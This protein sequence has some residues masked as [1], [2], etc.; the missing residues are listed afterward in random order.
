MTG[1]LSFI[2]LTSINQIRRH[3][4]ETIRHIHT[5]GIHHHDLRIDNIVRGVDGQLIVIDFGH[6][7]RADE[8][9]AAEL[10]PDE[11]FLKLWVR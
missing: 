2:I 3:L 9:K 10:C 4:D 8:C 5:A 7:S 6:S 1:K 11:I